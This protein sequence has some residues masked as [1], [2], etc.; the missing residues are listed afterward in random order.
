MAVLDQLGDPVDEHI[1][2]EQ[3]RGNGREAD[4][5]P[6][7]LHSRRRELGRQTRR[8][9]LK[10]PLRPDQ[11]LEPEFAQLE[12]TGALLQVIDRQSPGSFGEEDLPAMSRSLEAGSPAQIRPEVVT[13]LLGVPSPHGP[14]S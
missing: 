8:D 9:Q 12:E 1:A 2:P 10:H 6:N 4:T 3:A 5:C 7:P 13:V 11:P 14:R